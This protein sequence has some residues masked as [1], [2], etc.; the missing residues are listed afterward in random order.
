ML[1]ES[2]LC[3]A[4]FEELTALLQPAP[5]FRA[6][7]IFKWIARG[8]LD[9]EHMTDIPL[10]LREEL[11][12]RFTLCS[13]KI[14]SRSDGKDVVKLAIVFPDN[15][16]IESVLLSD[17]RKRRTACLSTQAGCP[18]GCVFCRTGSLGFSRNLSSAEIVE[19][20]L[21]LRSEAAAKSEGQTVD[22]IVVMGMGEPL[23]NLAEL[24]KALAIIT[25]SRGMH[26]SRRRITVSTCGISEG[27]IDL[28]EKGPSVRLALSLVT[29]DEP[30]RQKLMPITATQPLSKVKDALVF[31]QEKGGG[32][33]TLETVLLGGVNTRS[34]DAASI[35]KFAQGLDVVVN[36]IPWNPAA[37]LEYEGRPL[38]EPERKE[39][40]TFT[41]RLESLGLKTTRRL[42]KGRGVMGACGQLGTSSP[43]ILPKQ[44]DEKNLKQAD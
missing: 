27:I 33:V 20:F 17:G 41:W 4:P 29:A 2:P 37:G 1:I 19:Q 31:F 21:F 43:G 38:R 39:V 34:E 16:R 40:D 14:S 36:L 13:G 12:S 11:K 6:A 30:L 28:A 32:R 9:F 23:L 25:D 44:H 18:S 3:G 15:A 7:Q 42:K 24:R 35:A 8:V 26:F 5:R 22:N 10:A